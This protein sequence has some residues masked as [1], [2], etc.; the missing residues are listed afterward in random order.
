LNQKEQK[1]KKFLWSLIAVVAGMI[2]LAYASVP[3]YKLFCQV[4][5]YGGTPQLAY[6][7][8]DKILD[9]KITIRFNAD[10]NPNLPW[11]FK[12]LQK[13]LTLRIGETGV[14]FYMAE[15]VSEQ[16]MVGMATYNV[17]PLKA[18]QYFN[19]IECF[20]FT[21]QYIPPGVRMNMP[22]TFFIHPDLADDR[23]LKEVK[24]ITLSYTF[25][26]TKNQD[27]NDR[28]RGLHRLS[29]KPSSNREN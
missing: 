26:P 24:T 18:G 15:N 1:N 19:K 16:Q 8:A 12:P 21:D 22:V 17:T 3:L 2:M 6:E 20:C 13:D 25:F 10:I 28:E 5:G 23:N 11:T 27:I 9:R 7:A 4:T 29:W 14:A